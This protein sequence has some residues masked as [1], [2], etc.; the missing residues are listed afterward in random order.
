MKAY[1]GRY[2]NNPAK[3]RKVSIRIDK[4]DTWSMDSTLAKIIYPM[5][6]QLKETTHGAPG[7]LEPFAQTSNSIQLAFPFYAEEDH[8][9]W[10]AGHKLWMIMLDEMIWAFSQLVED[11]GDW[12]AQFHSGEHDTYFVPVDEAGNE[13]AEKGA[14]LYEVKTGPKNTHVFDYEGYLKH[15]TRMEAAFKLFGEH[16]MNLWD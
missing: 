3:D 9:A 11:D 15:R 16:Y 13:V 2:P 5:L 6:K 4:W 14:K 7:T 1:I 10:D 8:V 12:S